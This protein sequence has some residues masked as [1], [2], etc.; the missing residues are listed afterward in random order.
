MAARS[1]D[2]KRRRERIRRRTTRLDDQFAFTSP[3]PDGYQALFTR[4]E[5]ELRASQFLAPLPALPGM[6][7]EASK[8]AGPG[9]TGLEAAIDVDSDLASLTLALGAAGFFIRGGAVPANL[10]QLIDHVGTAAFR[11]IT[12]IAFLHRL[13]ERALP[14]Y[15]YEPGGLWRHLVATGVA[16]WK[17][18]EALGFH[19]LACEQAF[20]AGVL[21]DIGKPTIQSLLSAD[22]PPPEVAS[23]GGQLTVLEAERRTVNMTHPELVPLVL[24]IWGVEH[25]VFPVAEHHHA[26][27]RAGPKAIQ[28]SVLQLADIIANRAGVGLSSQYGFSAPVLDKVAEKLGVLSDGVCTALV[29]NLGWTVAEIAAEIDDQPER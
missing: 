25:D 21:H 22:A 8:P 3:G 19:R 9:T 2:A 10:M 23:L 20:F 7:L 5:A 17:I 12:L 16:A 28:A 1:D 14:W 26:P 15:G 6:V 4:G 18:S 27:Q 29:D 24:D 13:L 11:N